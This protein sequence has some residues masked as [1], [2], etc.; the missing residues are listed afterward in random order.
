MRPLRSCLL[1]W[2]RREALLHLARQMRRDA[3][4]PF[5]EHQLPA[6]MH[7]VLLHAH[8]HFEAALGRRRHALR[9]RERLGE[10]FVA[11][12]VNPRRGLLAARLQQLHEL[13]L[14]AQLR[15]LGLHLSD[16]RGKVEAIEACP[17][18]PVDSRE[19][20]GERDVRQHLTH[21]A[22]AWRRRE[23]ELRLGNLFGNLDRVRANGA[24]GAREISASVTHHVHA[25]QYQAWNNTIARCP[26][27]SPR[28]RARRWSRISVRSLE[29]APRPIR[30]SSSITAMASRGTTMPRPTSSSFRQA[31]A[32]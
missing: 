8:D 11:Q 12:G 17:L 24:I 13:R 2:P 1:L 26:R 30:R 22:H 15:F 6:M 16:H 19:R 4:H 10:E 25:L 27:Y 29:I 31:P 23:I 5:D 20:I 14:R 9:L 18:L 21:G 32:R 7:L 3:E 28:L